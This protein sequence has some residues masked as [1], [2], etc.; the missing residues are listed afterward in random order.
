LSLEYEISLP[1]KAL[2][3]GFESG[4][5]KIFLLDESRKYLLDLKG[6]QTSCTALLVPTSNPYLLYSSSL[7]S[8]V[9]IWNLRDFEQVYMLQLDLLIKSIRFVSDTLLFLT[10]D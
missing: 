6:H 10:T 9:R 1:S 5:I 2:A 8:T 3:V 4:V 7:D